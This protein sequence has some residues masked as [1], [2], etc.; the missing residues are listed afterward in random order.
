MPKRSPAT[1]DE[2]M[3]AIAS[4][5]I[6]WRVTKTVAMAVAMKASVAAMERGEAR[7]IPQT[8]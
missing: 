4:A 6:R 7:P 8:P 2:Q 1:K 3:T 5:P